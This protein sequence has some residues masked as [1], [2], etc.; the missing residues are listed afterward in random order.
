MNKRQIETMK[1]NRETLRLLDS[2]DVKLAAAGTV[3]LSPPS[4]RCTCGITC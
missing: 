2:V 4:P 1:L 3:I